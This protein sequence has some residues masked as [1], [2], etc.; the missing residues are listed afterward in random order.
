MRI[1]FI[2]HES[3]KEKV[4]ME[5]RDFGVTAD[6]NKRSCELLTNSY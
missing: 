4:E 6:V 5:R 2:K 3:Q 1:I